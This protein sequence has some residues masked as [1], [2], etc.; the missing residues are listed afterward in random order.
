VVAGNIV[1]SANLGAPILAPPRIDA[2]ASYVVAGTLTGDIVCLDLNAATNRIAPEKWR[3]STEA[4]ILTQPIIQGNRVIVGSLDDRLRII[5]ID[6]GKVLATY[7]AHEAI[8]AG[9]VALGDVLYVGT[10]E[11]RVHA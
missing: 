8:S 2:T 5:S 4:A 1:C 9:P 10:R 6:T 7:D 3:I 11:G